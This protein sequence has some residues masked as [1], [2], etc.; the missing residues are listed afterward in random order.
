MPYDPVTEERLQQLLT[1][2]GREVRHPG[3]VYLVGGTSLLYQGLKV[4]TKDVDISS[5]MPAEAREEFS[6]RASFESRAEHGY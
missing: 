2:L 4:V 5:R 6:R 1:R 3:R